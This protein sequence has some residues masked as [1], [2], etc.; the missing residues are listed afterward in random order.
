MIMKLTQKELEILSL[1]ALGKSNNKISKECNIALSTVQQ[2]LR[3]LM[4]KI[5]SENRVQL[6]Y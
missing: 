6:T 5:P 2:Y 3:I 1:V 4:T